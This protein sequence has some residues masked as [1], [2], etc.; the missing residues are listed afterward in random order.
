MRVCAPGVPAAGVPDK[1]PVVVFSCSPVGSGADTDQVKGAVPPER[2]NVVL[3]ERP[4]RALGKGEL[5]VIKSEVMVNGTG[6]TVEAVCLTG[7]L[8]S[9]TENVWF[10]VPTVPFN[11]MPLM[12]PGPT[13]LNCKPF[14]KLGDTDHVYGGTPPVAVNV[15]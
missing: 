7:E 6:G 10:V 5:V 2:C 1:T 13:I 11:G 14:G 8:L 9:I 4:T 3:Y 15:V 12:M